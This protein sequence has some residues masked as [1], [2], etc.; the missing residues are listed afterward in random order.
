MNNV[1]VVG[2][3]GISAT[4]IA[5]SKSV[6]DGSEIITFELEYHRYIHGEFMTHRL[7]SLLGDKY[8]VLGMLNAV[9]DNNDLKYTTDYDAFVTTQKWWNA[10][11]SNFATVIDGVT[12]YCLKNENG[13][14][15]KPKDFPK[16]DLSEF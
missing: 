1:K 15:V 11:T 5:H 6:V 14:V 2:K 12:Y 10:S 3:G 13:K 7:F 9:C 8:D 4:I 16:V